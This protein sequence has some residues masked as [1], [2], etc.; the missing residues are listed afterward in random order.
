MVVSMQED[1]CSV[2]EDSGDDEVCTNR[3]F[4]AVAKITSLGQLLTS[5][6]TA[7]PKRNVEL[8]IQTSHPSIKITAFSVIP[9]I[10]SS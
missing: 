10:A 5:A 3:P 4:R 9:P 2:R 8:L 7:L 1:L 6:A